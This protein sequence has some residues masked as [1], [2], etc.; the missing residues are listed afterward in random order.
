[1]KHTDTDLLGK[2]SVTLS[3]S[4]ELLRTAKAQNIDLS[5]ALEAQLCKQ[6]GT[7][8]SP[9]FCESYAAEISN[10]QKETETLK[11]YGKTHGIF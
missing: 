2:K 11:Q 5:Q 1:M 7:L 6:L 9:D 10:R 3:I 8:N 4:E